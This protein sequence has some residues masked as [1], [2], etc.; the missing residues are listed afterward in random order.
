MNWLLNLLKPKQVET[1]SVLSQTETVEYPHVVW[2]HGANQSS[3][4]FK[5]IKEKL[6][7]VPSTFVEY[8]SYNGF[9]KN[10]DEMLSHL[11]DR[12]PIFV[13]G[14]SLGGIYALHMAKHLNVI[15]GISISTPFRGSSMADWARYIVPKYQLFKDIGR[16][17]API[18]EAQQVDI[19]NIPWTQIVTTRGHAPWMNEPNDSVVTIESMRY[20]E[21]KMEIVEIPVNHYEV[22]CSDQT[23]SVIDQKLRCINATSRA[24]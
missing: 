17:S 19:S 7:H 21:D 16:K 8:S 5:Y 18:I 13:V 4:S 24:H 3:L 10:L 1:E 9:Y 11:Q 22:V 23:V 6:P 12:G 15:G 2:L 14:H 20:L